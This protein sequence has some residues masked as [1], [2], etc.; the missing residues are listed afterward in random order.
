M[1][2][3]MRIILLG[4]ILVSVTICRAS[5]FYKSVDTIYVRGYAVIAVDRKVAK[6]IEDSDKVEKHRKKFLIDYDAEIFFTET[7]KDVSQAH[8]LRAIALAAL[9]QKDSVYVLLRTNSYL[10]LMNVICFRGQPEIMTNQTSLP[11]KQFLKIKRVPALKGKRVT[12]YKIEA[13][14]LVFNANVCLK[15]LLVGSYFNHKS[16]THVLIPL[17]Y[18]SVQAL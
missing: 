17:E 1:Q 18:K 6:S 7:G 14:F 3:I 4:A 11:L 5:A 12:I 16:F 15:D 10:D 13:Y 8:Q 9:N 2:E